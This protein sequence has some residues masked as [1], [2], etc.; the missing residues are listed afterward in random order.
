[1]A[2]VKLKFRPSMVADRPGT[3][4]YLITHRRTVRQITTE[5][6]VF[7]DEWDEKQSRLETINKY[8]RAETVRIISRRIHLDMER[9]NTII[10]NFDSKCQEYSSEDIISEF[11]NTSN[12]NTL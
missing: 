6:R 8:E 1:M 2:T 3:I 4:I 7:S 9:L 5:Y 12:A 10:E 11:W